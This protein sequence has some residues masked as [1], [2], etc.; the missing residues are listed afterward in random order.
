MD[1]GVHTCQPQRSNLVFPQINGFWAHRWNSCKSTNN[2]STLFPNYFHQNGP[3]DFN[4]SK[5]TIISHALQ[6]SSIDTNL[7]WLILNEVFCF[8]CLNKSINLEGRGKRKGKENCNISP[9]QKNPNTLRK[10]IFGA[11]FSSCSAHV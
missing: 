2:K 4:S 7:L 3:K 8:F 11:E 10:L 1:S 6:T 9:I 5:E